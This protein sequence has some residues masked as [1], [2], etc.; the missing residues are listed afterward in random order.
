MADG[1]RNGHGG[2]HGLT[3]GLIRMTGGTVVILVENARVLDGG[4]LHGSRQQQEGNN[5]SAGCVLH[6]LCFPCR[7]IAQHGISKLEKRLEIT[8]FLRLS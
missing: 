6:R 3:P 7:C 8:A 5:P 2:M 4:R 1:A